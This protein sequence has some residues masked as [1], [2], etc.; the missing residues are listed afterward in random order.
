[1]TKQAL[2]LGRE[3][4]E[5]RGRTMNTCCIGTQLFWLYSRNACP[6]TR[7]I[8]SLTGMLAILKQTVLLHLHWKN[9]LHWLLQLQ[10]HVFNQ[11]LF[12]PTQFWGYPG[13]PHPKLLE[14]LSHE[15][16]VCALWKC[17]TKAELLSSYNDHMLATTKTS[18][19]WSILPKVSYWL[20]RVGNSKKLLH[21]V[22]TRV[23]SD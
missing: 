1:M 17:H 5:G 13:L 3:G 9:S 10:L 8:H 15:S 21:L 20:L 7:L 11:S 22:A 23:S 2:S 14:P 12:L 18:W 6:N 16:L 4:G 19:Q